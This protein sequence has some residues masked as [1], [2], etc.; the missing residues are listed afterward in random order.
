MH[1]AS[2]TSS[3]A[4]ESTSQMWAQRI[5]GSKALWVQVVMADPNGISVIS[6]A[7]SRGS[8]DLV[9]II[10]AGHGLRQ[11]SPWLARYGQGIVEGVWTGWFGILGLSRIWRM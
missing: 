1:A 3:E 5:V 8:V 2:E 6:Q 7:A 4:W 11:R 10:E 9:L